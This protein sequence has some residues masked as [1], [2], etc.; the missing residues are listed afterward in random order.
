MAITKI[1]P[2]VR[3]LLLLIISVWYQ[4]LDAQEKEIGA[5]L[6]GA[7]YFGDI[8]T[9]N[10]L[11]QMRPAGGLLARYN[12]KNFLSYKVA[13]SFGQIAGSD[14]RSEAIFQTVRGY[15]F[16]TNIIEVA[17]HVEVH[18]LEYVKGDDIKRFTPYIFTGLGGI[19]F[20]GN[21][22]FAEKE[23][24][25]FQIVIPYGVGIKYNL[26]YNWCIGLEAGN[27]ATFTDYL[28]DVSTV[29]NSVDNPFNIENKQRGSSSRKNDRYMFAGISLTYTWRVIRCPDISNIEL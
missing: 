29:Y 6:G 17:G 13:I 9:N 24:S 5:W 26:N 1:K 20:F 4:R 19:Y 14:N 11:L 27:R 18:F 15:S 25:S 2:L 16:R 7:T 23:Y 12:K 3:L 21:T 10:S 28:D 8:N 22:K